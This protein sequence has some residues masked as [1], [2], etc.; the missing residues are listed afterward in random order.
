LRDFRE[1]AKAAGFFASG[2]PDV[3]RI[4]VRNIT[5]YKRVAIFVETLGGTVEPTTRRFPELTKITFP[6]TEPS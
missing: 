6:T 1:R 5:G 2:G 4:A 3:F